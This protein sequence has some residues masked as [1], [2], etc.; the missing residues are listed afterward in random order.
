LVYVVGT[1]SVNGR[2]TRDTPQCR[3][4]LVTVRLSDNLV[5]GLS[6]DRSPMPGRP[7]SD[8]RVNVYID[9]YN[10]YVPLSTLEERQYELCWCDFLHLGDLLVR[11]LASVRPTEFGGGRLGAVKYFT[12]TI[13]DDMP[14]DREGI[15]R[16]HSWL[17][18]LHYHTQGK[19]EIVHGTFRPRQH[20]FYIERKELDNL[21]R[22]GIAV[23]WKLIREETTT[24]H[25][26]LRIHEE[27]QT[28]V[29]LACSLVTDAAL[30]AAG[31]PSTP[32]VQVAPQHHANRRPTP[33]ACDAAIVVSADID[34]LPA[35]E[36][37]SAVFHC[38][39][40]IAF[41]FP[42]TGYKLQ[43][44]AATRSLNLCTLEVSEDDLRQCMLP[45]E[46]DAKGRKIELRKVKSSHFGRMR[47]T[48]G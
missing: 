8:R 21:A 5:M 42:H 15:E 25:P 14:K 30:A 41:T 13:P 32:H 6:T 26:Q 47:A 11:R 3:A 34:F 40:A 36:V 2:V 29:M 1:P 22:S 7:A 46:V 44:V 33:S 12:A 37:A 10:F 43:D 38:P 9:G 35:A 31:Q 27:K 24:F 16:K 20:R 28:D 39:V 4:K 23:D 45:L 48:H 17:D 19:V 18:A